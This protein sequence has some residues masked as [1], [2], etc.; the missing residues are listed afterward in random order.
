MGIERARKGNG[1]GLGRTW[2]KSI[3]LIGL[4]MKHLLCKH[5]DLSLSPKIHH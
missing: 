2:L 5:G 3:L 4:S 1:V